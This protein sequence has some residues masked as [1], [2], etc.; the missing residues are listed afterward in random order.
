MC[1]WA[2]LVLKYASRG[3]ADRGHRQI[4]LRG[5]HSQGAFLQKG[6]LSAPVSPCVRGLVG[7]TPQRRGRPDPASV[8]RRPRPVSDAVTDTLSSRLPDKPDWTFLWCCPPVPSGTTPSPITS[9][10]KRTAKRVVDRCSMKRAP[11]KTMPPPRVNKDL[12]TVLEA[13][14]GGEFNH[15]CRYLAFYIA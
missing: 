14:W 8:H 9:A 15:K 11:A 7:G 2:D 5:S 4:R 10:R 3:W 12:I 1:E 6:S 13:S